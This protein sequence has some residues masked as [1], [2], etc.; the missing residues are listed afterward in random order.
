MI[1]S[2]KV[3]DWLVITVKCHFSIRRLSSDCWDWW[4]GVLHISPGQHHSLFF[5]HK[6]LSYFSDFP[7]CR[8]SWLHFN[9]YTTFCV[10]TPRGALRTSVFHV[11]CLSFSFPLSNIHR[12]FSVEDE[13]FAYPITGRSNKIFFL[14][15]VAGCREAR[16]NYRALFKQKGRIIFVS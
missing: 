1:T 14:V 4:S 5:E 12:E 7:E 6:A 15:H 3:F 11:L 16:N 8:E 13:H 9:P 2:Q 10:L